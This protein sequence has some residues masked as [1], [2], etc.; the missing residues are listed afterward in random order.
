MTKRP[1]L[2]ITP[3]KADSGWYSYGTHAETT[4]LH[5]KHM[6]FDEDITR[7]KDHRALDCGKTKIALKGVCDA[8]DR[9]IDDYRDLEWDYDLA[10]DNLKKITSQ[11]MRLLMEK[12]EGKSI[13][14]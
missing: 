14:I 3:K 6:I 2:W 9:L 12:N 13:D 4:I 1:T 5:T 7:K 11:Y 8:Y 10:Q